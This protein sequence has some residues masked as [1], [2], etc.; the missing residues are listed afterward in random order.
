[1]KIFIDTEFHE[2]KKNGI[3]TIELISLA[4]VKET[5]EQLYLISKDFN[6]KNAW[7]NEWLRDNVIKTLPIDNSDCSTLKAAKKYIDKEGVTREKM[8]EIILQFVGNCEPEFW[9]YYASYDWVVFCWI[10]GRMIELPNNFPMLPMDL[11][12]IMHLTSLSS[13]K[14]K[15]AVPQVNCHNALAD[16]N[17]NKDV[18]N[19]IDSLVKR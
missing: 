15:E 19:Y 1:M 11:K 17:W 12:Q 9:G 3:D 14:I 4:L 18:W 7:S 2:Y 10:F 6:L 13:D 8:K 5:G 16:A